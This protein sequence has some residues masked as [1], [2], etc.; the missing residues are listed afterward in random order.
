LLST[1]I[2]RDLSA[3]CKRTAHGNEGGSEHLEFTAST[4][5]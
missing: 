5:D 3:W 2:D 4:H 1:R